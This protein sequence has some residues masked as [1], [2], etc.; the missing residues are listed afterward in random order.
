MS[1]I[2]SALQLSSGRE[3]VFAETGGVLRRSSLRPQP[4]TAPL[5]HNSATRTYPTETRLAWLG[6]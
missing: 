3:G 6:M 2:L 5:A 1:A 4:L